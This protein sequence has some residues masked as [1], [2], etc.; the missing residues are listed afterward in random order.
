LHKL[1]IVNMPSRKESPCKVRVIGALLALVWLCAGVLVL[2]LGIIEQH[3]LLA[4]V[5]LLAGWYGVI[6]IYV[7]KTGRRLTTLREALTPWNIK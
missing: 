5:G 3:W 4:V 2:V 1:G 6:W 7:A